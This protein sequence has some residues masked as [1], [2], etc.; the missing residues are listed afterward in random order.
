MPAPCYFEIHADDC[1]RAQKFYGD[2]FGWSFAPSEAPI[3]NITTSTMGERMRGGLLKRPGM[4][5]PFQAPNAFVVTLLVTSVDACVEKAL[6]AGAIVAMAKFAVK[7]M[8][9]TAYLIDTEKNIFGIFQ[10]DAGAAGLTRRGRGSRR[11]SS[12]W[13]V[14]ATT[15]ITA[16]MATMPATSSTPPV[17]IW[18]C[19]VPAGLPG[20]QRA[21]AAK[22]VEAIR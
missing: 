5:Q 11:R 3:S 4:V 9:W 2:L 19:L 18:A 15:A 6:T 16:A 7:G 22:A 14:E 20:G 17:S 10:E 13:V 1:A 12:P 8:G 21:A